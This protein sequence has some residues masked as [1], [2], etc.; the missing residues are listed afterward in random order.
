MKSEHFPDII[1]QKLFTFRSRICR[2]FLLSAYKMQEVNSMNISANL[3]SRSKLPWGNLGTIRCLFIKY[4]VQ[5]HISFNVDIIVHN[6]K[7]QTHKITIFLQK[8]LNTFSGTGLR[9]CQLM[10]VS[11]MIIQFFIYNYYCFK[12]KILL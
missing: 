5:I 7:P 12:N 3:L 10:E 9:A 1:L 8:Y 11:S 2:K 4:R 6:S